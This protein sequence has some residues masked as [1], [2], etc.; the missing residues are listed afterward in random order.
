MPGMMIF[1]GKTNTKKGRVGQ[2]GKGKAAAGT[3]KQDLVKNARKDRQE[4]QRQKLLNASA[5]RIQAGWR[6]LLSSRAFK[7]TMQWDANPTAGRKK[8]AA[9][10]STPN[11]GSLSS[12]PQWEMH[13][14]V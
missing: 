2:R 4:R 3:N 1:D 14:T 7:H 5:C 10:G 8:S 9:V 13:P 6:A 11:S 12:R